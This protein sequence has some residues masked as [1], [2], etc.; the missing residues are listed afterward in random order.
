MTVSDEEIQSI[1]NVFELSRDPEIET[2][3]YINTAF[4]SYG[5]INPAAVLK[6]QLTEELSCMLSDVAQ[7]VHKQVEGIVDKELSGD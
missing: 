6:Y 1:I 5:S 4:S 3:K 2:S 7:T